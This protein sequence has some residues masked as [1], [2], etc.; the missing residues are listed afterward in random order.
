MVG[1]KGFDGLFSLGSGKCGGEGEG[2]FGSRLGL[3]GLFGGG[4]L[5]GGGSHFYEWFLDGMQ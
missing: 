2:G 3:L 4:W 5:G 1:K